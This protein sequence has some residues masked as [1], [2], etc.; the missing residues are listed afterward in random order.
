MRPVLQLAA[1]IYARCPF[2]RGPAIIVLAYHRIADERRDLAV[3][4]ERF[5]EQM[6]WLA[7]QRST[8]PVLSLEEAFNALSNGSAAHRSVVLTFDD[9]WA[10]NH[11][12]A[13]PALVEHAI[14][15]TLYVPSRLLGRPGHLS[16]S[17]LKAMVEGGVVVGAHSRTH[18]DLRTCSRAELEAEV[19]GSREDLEDILGRPVESF[20]YP[21][22]LHDDRVID[23]V[24]SAG[25]RSA[26]TASRGWLRKSSDRLRIPRSF[27]ERV[28][29][30]TFA[31]TARGGLNV[32]A[33]ADALRS[34][35]SRYP[36][37][38]ALP[39]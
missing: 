32:L 39:P 7:R 21:A 34:A 8:L 17:Q 19:R 5:A 33:P 11:E 2:P 20:S 31:A 27:V 14:P 38:A 29:L 36:A 1:R 35:A 30:A 26:V 4:P 13:L 15:A 3:S 23:A 37:S 10:D 6:A 28:P 12:Q 18:P 24:A 25:Y 22:G 16:L 9:A